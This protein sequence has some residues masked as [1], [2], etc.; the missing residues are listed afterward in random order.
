MDAEIEKAALFLFFSLAMLARRHTINLSKASFSIMQLHK[1]F[2]FL[3]PLSSLRRAK[4][5]FSPFFPPPQSPFPT[6][7][8][9]SLIELYRHS[10][11]LKSVLAVTS[12]VQ[13]AGW[14][15][16]MERYIDSRCGK[17][18]L[19]SALCNLYKFVLSLPLRAFGIHCQECAANYMSDVFIK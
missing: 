7:A 17:R 10:N 8:R 1:W 11:L 3:R 19:F 2:P 12:T 13:M 18:I 9:F 6:L 16:F 14:G 15:I 5:A 4:R